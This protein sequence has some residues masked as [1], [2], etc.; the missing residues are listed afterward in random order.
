[1]EVAIKKKI[2]KF[3]PQKDKIPLCFFDNYDKV[4]SKFNQKTKK[5]KRKFQN[6]LKIFY[7]SKNDYEK[8]E[9]NHIYRKKVTYIKKTENEKKIIN[10]EKSDLEVFML[11]FNSTNNKSKNT[12]FSSG[13]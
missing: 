6:L 12:F 2:E 3:S 1:M 7:D 10:N 11:K 8:D 5:Q 9:N 13:K 4:I